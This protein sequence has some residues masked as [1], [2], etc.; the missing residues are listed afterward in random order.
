MRRGSVPRRISRG[1]PVSVPSTQLPP[2]TNSASGVPS[3]VG[4]VQLQPV[5]GRHQGRTV[6]AYQRDVEVGID[7]RSAG[8]HLPRRDDVQGVE[9]LEHDDLD[10]HLL[11]LVLA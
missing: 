7:G 3:F 5:G 2:G 4:D 9:P 6:E 1:T 11:S 8:E 10:S